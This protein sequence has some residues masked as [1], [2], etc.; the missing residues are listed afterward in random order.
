[1]SWYQADQ[2]RRT[3]VY[4]TR[5]VHQYNIIIVRNIRPTSIGNAI[6]ALW[7][8]AFALSIVTL[9]C[10]ERLVWQATRENGHWYST[11][12]V[13]IQPDISVMNVI[14]AR[15]YCTILRLLGDGHCLLHS[16]LSSWLCELPDN[17][18]ITM[19][20]G[21]KSHLFIELTDNVQ[22]YLPFFQTSDN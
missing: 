13:F 1:M 9:E 11:F 20:E 19:L 15:Y 4:C 21:I 14:L 18:L 10:T 2:L 22:Y 6:I 5:K 7:M 3:Y 12:C 8:I 16:M 17:M